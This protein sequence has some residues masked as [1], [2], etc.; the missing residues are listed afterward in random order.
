[1]NTQIKEFLCP[2]SPRG[3]AQVNAGARPQLACITNYKAMGATSRDSLTMVMDPQAKPPYG[4]S[5]RT[6]ES[7]F[8]QTARY[9]RP[10]A[11]AL[12]PAP[13]R[14]VAYGHRDRNDRRGRQPLDSRHRSDAGRPAAEEFAHGRDTASPLRL[15]AP[16]GF[17][18]TLPELGRYQGRGADVPLLRLRPGADAGKYEDPGFSKPAPAYR[19]V[20]RTPGSVNCGMGDG[21]VH[22]I[23]RTDRRGR[24]S[25]S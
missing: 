12:V 16:P 1:M 6:L 17:D 21:A 20:V 23:S 25:S 18:N 19:S 14:H 3:S 7:R 10:A 5:S 2:N 4:P 13:G 15:F 22:A 24:P 9:F 8:I 11:L